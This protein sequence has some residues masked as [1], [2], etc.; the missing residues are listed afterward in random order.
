MQVVEFTQDGQVIFEY[1]FEVSHPGA[2]AEALRRAKQEF[3]NQFPEL[4]IRHDGGVAYRFRP[5]LNNPC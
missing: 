2:A 4:S 3:E 1:P 5:P